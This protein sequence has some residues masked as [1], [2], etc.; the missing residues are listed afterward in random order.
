MNLCKYFVIDILQK[1]LGEIFGY[2][3]MKRIDLY[4]YVWDCVNATYLKDKYNEI[5]YLTIE[6]VDNLY[7]L[8]LVL[9]DM[10]FIEGI[11]E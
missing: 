1:K 2:D 8:V 11:N 5:H 9:I 6:E 7:S 10:R 3:E 4:N